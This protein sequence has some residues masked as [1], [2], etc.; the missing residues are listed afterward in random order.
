MCKVRTEVDTAWAAAGITVKGA[1]PPFLQSYLSF[2]C[3]LCRLFSIFV[4]LCR[5][6]LFLKM[7]SLLSDKSCSTKFAVDS[8]AKGE[9]VV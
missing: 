2:Y 6:F 7:I 4:L 1:T 3:T 5:L 8:D 9:K